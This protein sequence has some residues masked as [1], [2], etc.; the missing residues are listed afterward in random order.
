MD[1][2]TR[3]EWHGSW[4]LLTLLG[5]FVIT[6]PIAVVYFIT[7]LLKIETQVSD[8]QKLSEFLRSKK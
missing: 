4:L 6:I 2:V 5:F 7:R 1:K 8:A 3:Y